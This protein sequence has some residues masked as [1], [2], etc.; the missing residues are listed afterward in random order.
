MFL[1]A[2][3]GQIDIV[4]AL[5]QAGA[6]ADLADSRGWTPLMV[7]VKNNNASLT[8]ILVREG[9]ANP[10]AQDK[11]GKTAFDKVSS[12][13][14]LNALRSLDD[15]EAALRSYAKPREEPNT[16]EVRNNEMFV[17]RGLVNQ[18]LDN[19][20]KEE[21][22]A[23]SGKL[24]EKFLQHS[25]NLGLDVSEKAFRKVLT[26]LDAKL[27]GYKPLLIE[28]TTKNFNQ[29]YRKFV[30]EIEK[31]L[32][33][34]LNIAIAAHNNEKSLCLNDTTMNHSFSE[35]MLLKSFFSPTGNNKILAS[36]AHEA[37]TRAYFEQQA[38]NEYAS[39]SNNR[40]KPLLSPSS[41]IPHHLQENDGLRA[42]MK[43]PEALNNSRRNTPLCRRSAKNLETSY[44]GGYESASKSPQRKRYMSEE[45]VPLFKKKDDSQKVYQLMVNQTDKMVDVI[46]EKSEVAL[47]KIFD[48]KLALL[49]ETVDRDLQEKFK[50]MIGFVKG[51]IEE[52]IVTSIREN[53][54]PSRLNTMRGEKKKTE[55]KG[56]STMDQI[57]PKPLSEIRNTPVKSTANQN[58]SNSNERNLSPSYKQQRE[59][60]IR[61]K[62]EIRMSEQSPSPQR[63]IE[64]PP[65][66]EVQPV[67]MRAI[68]QE[69]QQRKSAK[70]VNQENQQPVRTSVSNQKPNN[71]IPTPTRTVTRP[72]PSI[73]NNHHRNAFKAAQNMVQNTSQEVEKPVRDQPNNT[74]GLASQYQYSIQRQTKNGVAFSVPFKNNHN[75]HE[76]FPIASEGSSECVTE[77]NRTLNNLGLAGQSQQHVESNLTPSDQILMS[78]Y[79]FQPQESNN[80]QSDEGENNED[81]LEFERVLKTNNQELEEKEYQLNCLKSTLERASFFDNSYSSS[82]NSFST[83]GAA[84]ETAETKETRESN[85]GPSHVWKIANYERKNMKV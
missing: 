35:D 13:D 77:S 75:V 5:I 52:K 46:T 47:D 1:A 19:L 82:R 84:A 4:K 55:D 8:R 74:K 41:N 45:K 63:E 68:K 25:R 50:A 16:N 20:S 51:M 81:S 21:Y 67:R 34:K 48:S 39:P 14:I 31:Y 2:S 58:R 60:F 62:L 11:Y 71:K 17:L 36:S 29:K 30:K 59:E 85:K 80:Q 49:K 61:K 76:I 83:K 3:S 40:T 43:S 44:H 53:I 37:Q 24:K 32:N 28:E 56:T 12:V 69:A 78:N 57:I 27:V 42:Y 15:E 66:Q 22:G 6:D 7:A 79:S 38:L 73:L 72:P 10:K 54:R 18:E 64:V 23:I 9:K 65:R 26:D 70:K 33:L